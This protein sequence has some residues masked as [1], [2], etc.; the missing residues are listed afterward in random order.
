MPEQQRGAEGRCC[1]VR[2]EHCCVLTRGAQ[3]HDG[4]PQHQTHGQDAETGR[5]E[6]SSG[7]RAT[8]AR[9]ERQGQTDTKQWMG[10]D[11]QVVPEGG[12]WRSDQVGRIQ[13]ERDTACKDEI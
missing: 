12:A 5:N 13:Q 3:H 7:P 11:V 9:G 6:R 1:D 4:Q 2:V 10:A 8:H